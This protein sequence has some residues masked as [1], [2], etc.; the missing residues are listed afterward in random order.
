VTAQFNA[1]IPHG[2][3]FKESRNQCH[4]AL[5]RVGRDTLKHL[6]ETTP[7]SI[8]RSLWNSRVS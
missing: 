4:K 2:P 7:S 5:L 3:R 1:H 6:P 8:D